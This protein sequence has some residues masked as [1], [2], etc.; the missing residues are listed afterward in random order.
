MNEI[1]TYVDGEE[2]LTQVN[3]GEFPSSWHVFHVSRKKL[4]IL[5]SC[6]CAFDGLFA[7]FLIYLL[8]GYAH[9]PP[10]PPIGIHI[11]IVS[12]S[13]IILSSIV[14]SIITWVTMKNVVLVLTPF[15][16]VRGDKEKRKK[17][18]CINYQDVADMFVDNSVMVELKGNRRRKKQIDCRLFDCPA[19]EVAFSLL[20]A[21]EIFKANHT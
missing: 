13:M 8:E 11:I 2:V 18:L 19:R 7:G 21:Y 15:G 12:I 1:C 6:L 9:F 10:I 3:S 16:F 20:E 4:I 5:I 17:V 14:V